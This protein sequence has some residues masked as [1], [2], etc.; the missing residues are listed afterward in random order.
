MKN[1]IFFTEPD[2]VFGR[3][4]Y[5][6]IKNLFLRGINCH[7][8]PWN[9]VYSVAQMREI[10]RK[11]DLFVTTPGDWGA[12]LKAYGV[13]DP[14]KCAIIAHSKTDIANLIASHGIEEFEKV[15]KYAC[16]SEHLS[17]SSLEMGIKRIPSLTYI[18]ID[19]NSFYHKTKNSMSTAGYGSGYSETENGPIP[20]LLELDNTSGFPQAGINDLNAKLKRGW[21]AKKAADSAGID[22]KIAQKYHRSFVTMPGF[23]RSIDVLINPS[24]EEGAGMPVLEAAAAGK[25]VI[26]TASGYVKDRLKD[27]PIHIVP[28]DEENFL[29][30]TTKILLDYK[31][32]NAKYKK[33]C[34]EIQEHAKR[35]DWSN[36]IEGW[37]EFLTTS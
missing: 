20:Q 36:C 15:K 24:L 4:H 2:W 1:V 6:L 8:L 7:L 22:F 12:G 11:T 3:I 31:N 28:T 25:L 32:D 27:A 5:E 13:I 14:D 26:T 10:E 9:R 29:R 19:Y 17:R 37:V 34:E 33:R 16:V 18:G 23:Y 30:E 35:Y 21:L